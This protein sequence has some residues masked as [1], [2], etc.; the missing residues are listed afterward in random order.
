[1]KEGDIMPSPVKTQRTNNESVGLLVGL[2]MAIASAIIPNLDTNASAVPE[3]QPTP[4]VSTEPGAEPTGP[5]SEVPTDEPPISE[6]TTMLGEL[7]IAPEG[8]REGYDRNLF[9][10][11]IDADGDGCDTRAEVLK[12]QSLASVKTEA[13]CKVTEGQWFSVYDTLTFTVASKLDIDH[14]VP[15]AEAWDSGASAWDGTQREDYANDLDHP[16]ALIAVSGSSNSSKADR[17]PAEWRP[18]SVEYHCQ[19]AIEWITVKVAWDLS[20]DAAEVEA[21]VDLL[22]TCEGGP[23]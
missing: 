1:M 21:L 18:P 10:H 20:A 5:V 11:W 3:S 12:D 17:D 2:I 16:E 7:E 15:L 19:Y 8:P 6:V 13:R 23:Q 14:M 22:A 4:T 9:K